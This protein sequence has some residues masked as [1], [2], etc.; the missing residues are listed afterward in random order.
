MKRWSILLAFR[1]GALK[2]LGDNDYK[3]VRQAKLKS[4][5]YK[6]WHTFE[7]IGTLMHC[8]WMC[9]LAQPWKRVWHYIIKISISIAS[10]FTPKI[11]TVK[12]SLCMLYR[13]L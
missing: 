13:Y 12:K 11:Y 6:S 3:S 8:S 9:K 1:E 7:T 10:N 4:R 2:P 5:Q